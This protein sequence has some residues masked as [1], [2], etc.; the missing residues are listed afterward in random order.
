MPKVLATKF[1]CSSNHCVVILTI[2][3]LGTV[4]V[5]SSI[6]HNNVAEITGQYYEGMMALCEWNAVGNDTFL[7][8]SCWS[9]LRYF[10]IDGNSRHGVHGTV[11]FLKVYP[12]KQLYS[13]PSDHSLR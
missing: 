11:T 2:T 10:F 6:V 3:E 9:A 5:A 13:P 7:T 4:A 12:P 1:Q 8:S